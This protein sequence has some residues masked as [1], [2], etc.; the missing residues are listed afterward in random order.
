[1]AVKKKSPLKEMIRES[2]DELKNSAFP[3]DPTLEAD[4]IT[5][6]QAFT[7]GQKRKDEIV[8]DS[9]L[10]DINGKDGYFIKLKKEMR[11]NEWMLMKVV[12]S[13]WRQWADME[14]S[15]A[16]IVQEHTRKS[17]SKWGSGAY[18]VE[19]ACKGGIRGKGYPFYDFFINAEEEFLAPTVGGVVIPVADPTTQVTA[20]L[21]MLGRLMDVLK[22]VQ[23]TPIDPMKIQEQNAA[24]FQQGLAIKANEGNQ[25][26]QMMTAMM[27]G[28]MG[29]MT[30][31][32]TN[33]PVEPK[34]VNP[35]DG[36][37]DILETLKT[38]GVL[39]SQNQERPKST[40]EFLTE[41]K[42][43][44]MDVFKKDDPLEQVGKLKQIASIASDFMGMGGT[45]ERP[46]IIE[47][48]VDALA[49]AIPGLMH[50]IKETA[51]NAVK[52]Q[53]LA[54]EN[55]RIAQGRQLA[56]PPQQ[57]IHEGQPMNGQ[58]V[59]NEQVRM[60]FNSLYDA[61]RLNNRMF[62]PVIYTSLLQEVQGQALLQGILNSTH[63]AKEVIELLQTNGDPRFKD[64][65]FVMKH[66]VAYTNGFIIWVR[67]MMAPQVETAQTNRGMNGDTQ[68]ATE[69][70]FDVECPICKAV[71]VYGSEKEF[72]DE[73]NKACGAEVGG[74]MCPGEL[75]PLMKV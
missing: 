48:L 49:P 54:G 72:I 24:A 21:D 52:V 69:T 11:P 5:G 16:N 18:R 37:K 22:G 60:F 75:K 30:A 70:A 35:S 3:D 61:V 51:S 73:Q 39:G 66:L 20:Q 19:I 50:D 10:A 9:L 29:M 55:I 12:D 1:M 17:P 32:A 74:K 40:I 7:V 43:L 56:S 63:T 53:Q 4:E 42:A 15:I 46:S 23:P 71:Y 2:L 59:V 33:K 13:D 34:V 64:S 6:P 47:K 45:T 36:M 68:K 27:T 62:Y 38:F 26:T 31:M 57:P 8:I 41:L 58:P 25:S 44:G 67:S 14:S 28:L 65:E